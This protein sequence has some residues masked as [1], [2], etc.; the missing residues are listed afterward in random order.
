MAG[1][2]GQP[3]RNVRRRAARLELLQLPPQ[4]N[5]LQPVGFLALDAGADPLHLGVV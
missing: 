3:R 5:P 1:P 2:L 4:R